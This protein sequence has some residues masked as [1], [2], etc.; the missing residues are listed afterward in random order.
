MLS[1]PLIP[2]ESVARTVLPNGLT[3]LVRRDASAPVVAIVTY[4]KAGYFDETDD[5]AGIAHV[6]EHIYFKGTG[7]RGVG[8]ISRETKA[9]GGYINAGTIYDHTSYYTVVPS[10]GFERALDIQADAYANSVI[11][12]AELSRELEVIIQ[13][14]KRKRDNPSA[15]SV[16]TLYSL[17]YDKH[18]MRRWR[19][20]NENELRSLTRDDLM[21]FYRAFYRPHETI[22]SIVGDVDPDVALRAVESHYGSLTALP[23]ERTPGPDEPERSGFRYRELSGDV[24]QTQLVF[25]WRTQ[26]TLHSDTA[27]LE[28]AAAILGSGRAS[29][30]YRAVRERELAASVSAYDYTPT[31]LGVFVMRAEGPPS[32]ARDAAR[33]MWDQLR[34]VREEGVGKDEL[35]RVRRLLEARWI[36]QL[37]TMD[38]QANYLAEWEALGDWTLGD[39]FLERLLTVPQETVTE[40]TRRYLVPERAAVLAYRPTSAPPLA[41]DA[42]DMMRAL[43]RSPRPEPLPVTPPFQARKPATQEH[44]PELERITADVR[45]YRS[46]LG[47]PILVRTRPSDGASLVHAGIYV[48]GGATAEPEVHA[49]LTMLMTRTSLKGTERRTAE[50]I[51]EEAELLGGTIAASTGSESFGWGMSVPSGRIAA[52][53]ELLS[54]VAQCATFPE[55]TLDTERAI[56][57]AGLEQLRDDMRRYPMRLLTRAA[58]PDHPYGIPSNGF[59]SSLAA[60]DSRQVREWHRQRVLNSHAVVIV[61]GDVDPDE[62]AAAAARHFQHIR[63]AERAP[64]AAPDWPESP[65]VSYE[66]RE[67]AQTAL[68]LAFPSP[69]RRDP[70]RYTARILSG[71]A[72][73]LGGRFFE[74][75]R[76]KRSLAY[77]V[78]A[79]PVER[80]LAGMFVSYIAT[81][82]ERE[83]E[84]RQG[85]LDEFAKLRDAPVTDA[86][87]ARAIEYE[88]GTHAIRQQSGA[89]I[90]GDILDAYLFGTSLDELTEHDSRIRS[91]TAPD[92]LSLA[93]RYFDEERLVQGVVRGR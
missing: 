56:A 23:V 29:R 64:V 27:P 42:D 52:A 68:A 13:E 3:V 25:G 55:E 5:V 59:E 92:I 86:E 35:W 80:S 77:T 17:L 18:R 7:R 16:E 90:L 45:V 93:R 53:L 39:R 50:C 83:D 15:V 21:S 44:P 12:A 81:S 11:D 28:L 65:V 19:I 89:A 14:A 2:P 24:T 61:V 32:S 63:P 88:I 4:V 33:A 20:G 58:F 34:T 40:V 82:P 8:E 22:L 74:E 87:L 36:R 30:L 54:D 49:G 67:K 48:L 75:L 51:A 79:Y 85:L 60:I 1:I 91:V 43:E 57:V 47:L 46:A 76:D 37:E 6:L 26:G 31:E 70:D 66:S 69:D 10:S 73:G 62:A 41:R 72:S 78:S 9:L 84:A 38:G 71:I